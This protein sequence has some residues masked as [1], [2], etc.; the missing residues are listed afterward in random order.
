M[1]LFYFKKP[2]YKN[3]SSGFWKVKKH[4]MSYY[5]YKKRFKN[6]CLLAPLQY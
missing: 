4:L 5:I 6:Y 3:Q 2:V 1:H